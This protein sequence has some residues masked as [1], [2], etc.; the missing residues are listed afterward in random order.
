MSN[1]APRKRI[2]KSKFLDA[3]FLWLK[4]L[5][6]GITVQ[7]GFLAEDG[8]VIQLPAIFPTQEYAL[9]QVDELR[10]VL[11][12]HFAQAAQVGAQVISQVNQAANALSEADAKGPSP[13][14]TIQ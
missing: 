3:V 14:D 10:K 2:N 7:T 9:S 12:A 1:R 13:E 11:I 4:L 5:L 8:R 6:G